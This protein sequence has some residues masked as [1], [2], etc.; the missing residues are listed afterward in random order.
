MRIIGILRNRGFATP[1]AYSYYV[2]T[3]FVHVGTEYTYYVS[4]DLEQGSK[5]EIS[6]GNPSLQLCNSQTWNYYVRTLEGASGF[7]STRYP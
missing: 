2:R 4:P 3:Y 1:Y 5:G 7:E 6:A